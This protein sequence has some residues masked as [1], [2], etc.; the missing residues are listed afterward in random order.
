MIKWQNDGSIKC[1]V[2]TSINVIKAG[3]GWRASTQ[4]QRY[5]CKDCG[6]LFMPKD[7]SEI[8]GVK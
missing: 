1:D 7:D 5:R 8:T 6:K 2:C 4:H 3:K